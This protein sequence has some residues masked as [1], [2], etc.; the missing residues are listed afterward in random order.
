VTA[1]SERRV[2]WVMLLTGG[3]M[4]AQVIG[5][6]WSGSLALLADSGHML[7]DTA[8]LALAWFAFRLA[9]KP[10]DAER[11]YG[12]HRFQILAAF[13]NGLTLFLIAG[14]IVFEATERV[15]APV[16]VLG[17]PMLAVA[18]VGL[19]VNVAGFFL[20]RRGDRDNV[21]MRGALLHVLGDLLGSAAAI[22]A[23]VVILLTG[24]TPIDPILSVLVALLILKS[25][26]GLARNSGHI[27][28]EGTPAG[29]EPELVRS[30]LLNAVPGVLDVHHVH[31]WSLTAERKLVT[32][33]L[34]L[35]ATAN[36]A[37]VLPLVKARLRERFGLDHCTVQVDPPEI[38]PG[39]Q[40][41][42]PAR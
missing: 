9:K 38:C 34:Q 12:Y 22:A 17:G 21:N 27:L 35:D 16:P 14:W 32:L 33:H 29:I 3:Y 42:M 25:A 4:I 20:L 31:A 40:G 39:E 26:Y 18:I 7:S 15:M 13:V 36:P 37:R 30:D 8:A 10:S 28:M 23:A 5:G 24:W 2:F 41:A 1:D 11:S 19:L 6:L